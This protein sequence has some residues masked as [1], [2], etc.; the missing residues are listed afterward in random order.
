MI[1]VRCRAG[2]SHAVKL[3]GICL[4]ESRR[5]FD[6]AHVDLAME[7]PL[8]EP[9]PP[10]LCQLKYRKETCHD[11]RKG[12]GFEGEQ[13]KEPEPAP[14]DQFP[15]YFPH[16]APQR[17]FFM[18]YDPVYPIGVGIYLSPVPL[19]QFLVN[20]FQFTRHKLHC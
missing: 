18:P 15:D 2:S 13:V 5:H 11:I 3:P 6:P 1:S 8:L 20:S 16:L 19:Q 14:F 4:A 10:E 7:P 17:H 9:G 12:P